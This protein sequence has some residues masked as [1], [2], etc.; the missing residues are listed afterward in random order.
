MIELNVATLSNGAL[1]ERIHEEITKAV[2]NCLDP[3][4]EAKK[5]RKVKMEMTIKPHETRTMAEV[6]VTV[7]STLC[8]ACPISTSLYLGHNPVTGE[9][10]ASEVGTGENP[11]QAILPD[12]LV[13]EPLNQGKITKFVKGV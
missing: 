5:A 2:A 10:G 11:G 1:V 4:T 13:E 7:S 3:N 12:P 6:T 8:P 9:I